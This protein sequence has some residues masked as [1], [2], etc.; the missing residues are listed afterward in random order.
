MNGGVG[1]GRVL[2]G[3]GPGAVF[4]FATVGD[5]T[6]DE[7]VG[8]QELSFVGGNAVNVAVRIAE[9]GGDVAY[10]G[11]VGPDDRGARVRHALQERR[12]MVEHLLEI[13]GTTSTSQ[14]RVEVSGERHLSGE[15]FGTCADYRPTAGELDA[16]AARGV[17]HVGWTPFSGEIRTELRRRGA[18]VS[19]DCA[20]AEGFDN[21]D[22]AFC[23]TGVE[24][25]A[26]RAAA[27]EALAG[28]A[29]L[30]VVTRGAAGSIASDGTRWWSQEALPI[31][32]VD[33]TGAGDSFI[34]GFLLAWGRGSSVVRSMGAGAAAAAETCQHHGGFRQVPM[35]HVKGSSR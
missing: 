6:I 12:V 15:D 16:M 31:V 20:V 33:T 28:G 14:V 29:R 13:P 4:R 3:A 21:L 11:A 17:V 19:Q 34:A 27:H 5:N 22:V 10:F 26:A 1:A 7:Y 18:V 23:S 32:P 30:V 35:Q 25:D 8:A 2:T 24:E 9:L